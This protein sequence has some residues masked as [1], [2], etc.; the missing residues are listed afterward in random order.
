MKLINKRGEKIPTYQDHNDNISFT[1]DGVRS[2]LFHED[3]FVSSYVSAMFPS[4][5]HNRKM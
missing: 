2:E 5:R 1:E 4:Y 3:N